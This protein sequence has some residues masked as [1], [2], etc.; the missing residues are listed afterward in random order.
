VTL[1]DLET[2]VNTNEFTFILPD[3]PLKHLE[4]LNL[5]SLNA[6]KWCQGQKVLV[7]ENITDFLRVYDEENLFLGIGKIADNLL[8]PQMVFRNL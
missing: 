4:K 6:T 3:A 2:Q 8:I 5:P 1:P 7:D